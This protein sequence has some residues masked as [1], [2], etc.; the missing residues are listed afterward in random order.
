[1]E[2]VAPNF[3]RLKR[4][5]RRSEIRGQQKLAATTQILGGQTFLPDNGRDKSGRE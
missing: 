4:T 3:S 5:Y 1:L 2:N